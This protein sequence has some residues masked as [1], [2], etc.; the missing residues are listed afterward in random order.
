MASD[1]HAVEDL[2]PGEGGAPGGSTAHVPI[3]LRT[4]SIRLPIYLGRDKGR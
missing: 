1:Q 4:V 2:A 3:E